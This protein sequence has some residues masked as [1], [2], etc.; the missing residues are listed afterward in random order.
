MIVFIA[1]VL[2][3]A[4]VVITVFARK[5]YSPTKEEIAHLIENRI[6]LGMSQEWDYF[7]LVNI[8]D[9]RLDAIRERCLEL[10]YSSA[11][12]REHGLKEILSDLRAGSRA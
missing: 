11:E 7:R 4:V 1:A 2:V 8:K 10:D 5:R 12:R 9:K 3:L 6:N